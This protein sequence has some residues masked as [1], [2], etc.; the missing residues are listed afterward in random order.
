MSQSETPE[1][2]DFDPSTP[3]PLRWFCACHQLAF[4]DRRVPLTPDRV[5]YRETLRSTYAKVGRTRYG[6]RKYWVNTE[7]WA[8][9]TAEECLGLTTHELAHVPTLG[10]TDTS[11]HGPGFWEEVARI[12][13]TLHDHWE[14]VEAI[15]GQS[16]DPDA[17]DEWLVHD[18]R[19]HK[20]DNRC[21]TAYERRRELAA[22]L[23]YPAD[24]LRPFGG[25]RYTVRDIRE[26]DHDASEWVRYTESVDQSRL[27]YD[28]L[29]VDEVCRW[30]RS[31]NR[32]G[33]EKDGDLYRFDPIVVRDHG[34][35]RLEVV[36]GLERLTIVHHRK[37]ERDHD[38]NDVSVIDVADRDR[39]DD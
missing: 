4:P 9:H 17:Y 18:P 36:E 16:L 10:R 23:D 22:A 3:E 13:T 29:P 25:I 19:T 15:A 35:G 12:A 20:V 32:T 31:P 34:D 7:W 33:V 39:L 28:P 2:P 5:I 37:F 26:Y 8:D 38:Y 14:S 21:E 27:V 1:L 30:L 11:T 6:R 24:E